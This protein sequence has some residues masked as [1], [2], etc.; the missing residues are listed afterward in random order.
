M[1]AGGAGFIGSHIAEQLLAEKPGEM[2]IVDNLS[3]GSLA[4]IETVLRHPNVKFIEGD[5]RDVALLKRCVDAADYWIHL[6]A[7]RIPACADDTRGAFGI[8]VEGLFEFLELAKHSSIKKILFPSSVAVYGTATR[9]PT[10]ESEPPYANRSFYGAAKFFGEQ[11]LRSYH[12]MHGL[13]YLV[14]RNVNT[15]GPRMDHS[16]PHAEVVIR[17]MDAMERGVSPVIHGDGS[18]TVDFV[19][20]SDVARANVL[21]LRSN[22]QDD[23][24]NI[25]AG[26]EVSLNHLLALLVHVMGKPT[27]PDFREGNTIN[28]VQRRSVDITK[29]RLLLGYEPQVTLEEG[30]RS[31]Y[32]WYASR[33]T[34]AVA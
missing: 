17:W 14:L 26:E 29:A 4:N 1:L 15:Y 5:L 8:M 30:L 31:L 6:P 12:Q 10:P 21:A 34:M 32:A 7:P 28:P 13:P 3:R 25:G 9:F 22:L 27:I 2:L 24:L 20:V 23:I 16:G 19:H 11:L 18:T 33:A